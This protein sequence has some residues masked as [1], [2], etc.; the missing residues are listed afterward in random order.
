MKIQVLVK[1]KYMSKRHD[2]VQHFFSVLDEE[3]V[4]GV[5]L[6]ILDILTWVRYVPHFFFPSLF[7]WRMY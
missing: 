2:D 3:S 7:S 1:Q 4:R 6:S 5:A